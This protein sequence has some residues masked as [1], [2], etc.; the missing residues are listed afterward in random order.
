[1]SSPR[2]DATDSRQLFPLTFW[3]SLPMTTLTTDEQESIERANASGLQPV[4]FVHGLWL[5]SSSWDA[6]RQFFEEHG[7]TTIAPGWPDDPETIEEANEHP[8]VFAH[9]HIKQVTD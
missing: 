2:P 1:M 4:V 8:E 9:K 5:L 6:W 7:Y 3:R